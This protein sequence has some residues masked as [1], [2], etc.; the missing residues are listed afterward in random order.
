[1]NEVASDLS[2]PANFAPVGRQDS[3]KARLIS[4]RRRTEWLI[5]GCVRGWDGL[6]PETL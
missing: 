3:V 1:M 6:A 4:T 5:T 2:R